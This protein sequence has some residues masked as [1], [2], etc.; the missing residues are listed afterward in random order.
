MGICE[1]NFF[2]CGVFGR[3]RIMTEKFARGRTRLLDD[4]V[5]KH[6]K[7]NEKVLG[8]KKKDGERFEDE[9]KDLGSGTFEVLKGYTVYDEDLVPVRL[10]SESVSLFELKRVILEKVCY[11]D[12]LTLDTISK[13]NDKKWFD[14]FCEGR[15]AAVDVLVKEFDLKLDA[16]RG[17]VEDGEKE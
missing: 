10:K 15:D 2:V 13:T 14:A 11:W 7:L 6:Q 1:Q 5:E 12:V 4:I 17:Q 3:C 8:F 9:T 16:V